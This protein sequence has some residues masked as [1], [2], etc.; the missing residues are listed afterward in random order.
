MI[1]D[2]TDDIM[3]DVIMSVT[4]HESRQLAADFHWTDVVQRL[5]MLRRCGRLVEMSQTCVYF[6][7]WRT[8]LAGNSHLLKWLRINQHICH[9]LLS[10]RNQVFGCEDHLHNDYNVSSWMLCF[11]VYK[12]LLLQVNIH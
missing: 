7:M 1:N 8:R 12:Y 6:N 2:V 10:F 11:S 3:R 4:A 5:D 9:K